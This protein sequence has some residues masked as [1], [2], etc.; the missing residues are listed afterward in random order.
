M[1]SLESKISDL[2]DPLDYGQVM[3]IQCAMQFRGAKSISQDMI[4]GSKLS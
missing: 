4:M 1:H 2:A 3:N